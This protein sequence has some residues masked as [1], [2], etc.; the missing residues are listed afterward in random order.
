MIE[1][2]SKIDGPFAGV[3]PLFVLL[4]VVLLAAV[5][6]ATAVVARQV[7]R[8][9]PRTAVGGAKGKG[10]DAAKAGA[11]FESWTERPPAQRN[12]EAEYYSM[13]GSA[14]AR[15][16]DYV[17]PN[18]PAAPSAPAATGGRD[19]T[20]TLNAP[21]GSAG[22][23]ASPWEPAP[24]E[25]ARGPPRAHAPLAPPMEPT[26]PTDEVVAPAHARGARAA[27]ADPWQGLP[28]ARPVDPSFERSSARGGAPPPAPPRPKVGPGQP[29]P[30]EPAAATARAPPAPPARPG[31]ARSA[32]RTPPGGQAVVG[33][34]DV[35]AREGAEVGPERK[36][37]RC[38]K[39]S[40]VFPGPAT[41][42]ATVKCPACGTGGVMK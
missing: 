3:D 23:P 8:L 28:S 19:V 6:G 24:A 33:A 11:E 26:G 18:A 13:Y 41:R 10:Q 9:T 14:P 20:V 27:S 36:A 21:P 31:S 1:H 39:C 17:G 5:I 7:A 15:R 30:R 38:P 4:G 32:F 34:G 29:A 16:G 25:W 22:E 37:I 42:P 40:T 35:G 2:V 12:Y